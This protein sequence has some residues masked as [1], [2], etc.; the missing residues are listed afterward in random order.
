MADS[1]FLQAGTPNA[2]ARAAPANLK[3]RLVV[4][5]W[6]RTAAAC[7]HPLRSGASR[8]RA[9]ILEVLIMRR[10]LLL[11]LTLAAVA[12]ACGCATATVAG[13]ERMLDAWV[14]TDEVE[15]LRAWGAPDR[16]YEAG[17][18][19]FIAYTTR[20][21]V[22]YPGTTAT[23]HVTVVDGTAHAVTVGGAPGWSEERACSTTFELDGGKV[24]A[25]SHRGDDCRA[26]E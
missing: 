16:S 12:L 14:G 23:T 13:Y 25:W 6:P 11:C 17:G 5:A 19:R 3:C 21:N 10:H 1:R 8:H 22:H 20:R 15:L 4:M 24:V 2:G 7:N 18:R 26:R 9:G